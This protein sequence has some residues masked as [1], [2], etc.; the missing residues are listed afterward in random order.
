MAP[1]SGSGFVIVGGRYTPQ[2]KLEA[3]TPEEQA[4]LEIVMRSSGKPL[5]ELNAGFILK[6][7]RVIGEL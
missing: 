7:V 6:Q 3:F 1:K 2:R 4:I 5:H